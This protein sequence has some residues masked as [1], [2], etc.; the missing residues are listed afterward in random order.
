MFENLAF[1][2]K[3]ICTFLFFLAPFFVFSQKEISASYE[4]HPLQQVLQDLEKNHGIVFSYTSEII[5]NQLVTADFSDKKL[6]PAL[7]EI[8]KTTTID[9]KIINETYVVLTKKE[10]EISEFLICGKITDSFDAP[11]PFANIFIKKNNQGTSTDESGKFN[12]QGELLPSDTIEIS[13]VGFQTQKILAKNLA[14][15]PD[16]ILQYNESSFLE[17][18]VKEYITAGIEQSKKLDHLILRPNQI[19]VVP[20]LTRT[21]ADSRP[22]RL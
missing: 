18:I 15:C 9:F 5:E 4:N 3:F 10:F 14:A 21:C 8:F 13:Y 12:W 1:E 6:K 16:I 11:L 20:G 7:Q 19:D 17:V 22:E 2:M